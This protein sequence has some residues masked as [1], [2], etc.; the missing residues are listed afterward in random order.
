MNE[1]GAPGQLMVTGMV[2]TGKTLVTEVLMS[3]GWDFGNRRQLHMNSL[4]N[5][6]IVR[7]S[8]RICAHFE[9]R[10]NASFATYNPNHHEAAMHANDIANIPEGRQAEM[11]NIPEAFKVA[12]PAAMPILAQMYRP[13][14]IVI[15]YDVNLEEWAARIR[16]TSFFYQNAVKPKPDLLKI[17]LQNEKLLVSLSLAKN[18]PI[19]FVYFDLAKQFFAGA[20][21]AF[22][23]LRV[24]EG[25]LNERLHAL[26]RHYP[27][28]GMSPKHFSLDR[29]QFPPLR[30]EAISG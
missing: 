9:I 2:G 11:K 4:E 28:L 19:P 25:V 21:K 24:N 12:Y 16:R 26:L 1:K 8:K 7:A 18:V 20:P 22:N 17:A 15:C 13:K 30:K 29:E 23:A 10:Y 5:P 14:V 27:D 6:A 3:V